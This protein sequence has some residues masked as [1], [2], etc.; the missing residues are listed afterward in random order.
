MHLC[1]KMTSHRSAIA[2]KNIELIGLFSGCRAS[3]KATWFGGSC[4]CSSDR[5]IRSHSPCRWECALNFSDET[6]GGE[7]QGNCLTS[8]IIVFTANI[9]LWC[10]P[11]KGL[12]RTYVFFLLSFGEPK[13]T[14]V[15]SG[16]EQSHNM[17]NSGWP[18]AA[19][20]EQLQSQENVSL[21]SS[22]RCKPSIRLW[23]QENLGQKPWHVSNA[24][25]AYI[26]IGPLL[27]LNFLLYFLIRL[28][29]QVRFQFNFSWQELVD[30]HGLGH[31]NGKQRIQYHLRLKEELEELRH[32]C[33]VLLRERF[34]LEQCIRQ[35]SYRIL[36]HFE[37]ICRSLS[38][39]KPIDLHPW[40]PLCVSC[41][42]RRT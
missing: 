19:E 31:S 26:H 25:S 2:H 17:L 21:V 7:R 32:E 20:C 1:T 41:S 14:G 24:L 8:Y 29:K 37:I 6:D 38:Y 15:V 11:P 34:Q 22:T 5:S 16:I 30:T 18:Y 33:M 28:D 10:R 12:D 40:S 13:K 3:R 27:S 36:R 39:C 9:T 4:S 23:L 42:Y 35:G